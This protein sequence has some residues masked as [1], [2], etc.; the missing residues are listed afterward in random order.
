M[1]L[2]ERVKDAGWPL[3][4]G[5]CQE[6]LKRLQGGPSIDGPSDRRGHGWPCLPRQ[7]K[8]P[9]SNIGGH[10]DHTA[11]EHGD[12]LTQGDLAISRGPSA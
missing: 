9:C 5:A 6:M 11:E 2:A 7:K 4:K 12:L 8:R 3:P 10:R 1:T